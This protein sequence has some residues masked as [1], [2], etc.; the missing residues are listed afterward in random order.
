MWPHCYE[1]VSQ[2]NRTTVDLSPE[3]VTEILVVDIV[4][5]DEQASG[6]THVAS[7]GEAP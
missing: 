6:G 7:A 3:S 5:V 1:K 4:G 2:R